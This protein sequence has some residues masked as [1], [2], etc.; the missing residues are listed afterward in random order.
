MPMYRAGLSARGSM[1]TISAAELAE[2]KAV[3]AYTDSDGDEFITT[4]QFAD[5]S[6]LHATVLRVTPTN[7][8]GSSAPTEFASYWKALEFFVAFSYSSCYIS[9]FY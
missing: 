5:V 9:V 6:L 4:T 2:L 3:F 1:A 7:A 8:S